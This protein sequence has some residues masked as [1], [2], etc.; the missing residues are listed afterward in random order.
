[1]K[2]IRVGRIVAVL[3]QARVVEPFD[4]V[5]VIL[6]SADKLVLVRNEGRGWEFPGGHREGDETCEETA[7]REAHEEAGARITGVEYLG[8]YTT[9]AGHVTAIACAEVASF[10]GAGGGCEPLEVGMFDEL[11]S[12]LSFGDGREQLFL[13]C[14][15]ALR[16]GLGINQG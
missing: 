2:E 7:A 11:P 12:D 9:P 8:Y 3:G 14:A 4:A 16:S 5:V 15:R 1:M 10:E 6:F 13:D